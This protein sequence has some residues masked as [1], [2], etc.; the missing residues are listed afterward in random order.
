[1]SGQLEVLVLGSVEAHR[2]AAP[3]ALG[4][5]KLQALVAALALGAPHP[6][7]GDRLIDELWGEQPP[8]NPANALQAQVSHA[9]RLLGSDAV[10]RQGSAYRLDVDP[11]D[12]DANRLERLAQASPRRTRRRRPVVGDRVVRIGAGARARPSPGGARRLRVRPI[13]PRPGWTR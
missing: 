5:S 13:A 3:V 2:D 8:A 7:S 6:M 4:G 10:I 1:M 12:V 9:R 11:D